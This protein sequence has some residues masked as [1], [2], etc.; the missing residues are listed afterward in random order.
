MTASEYAALVLN[1]RDALVAAIRA[2][3]PAVC[4][5][6]ARFI[7]TGTQ[8][9]EKWTGSL[10]DKETGKTRLLVILMSQLK[11]SDLQATAGA[12]NFKPQI[13]LNFELFH[14]FKLGTD[15]ENSEQV[16]L[17]DALCLQFA[18]ESNRNLP[19]QG[20]IDDYSINLGLRPSS[21]NAMHYGRGT[22]TINFREIR[23]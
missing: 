21:V 6:K 14:D 20:K 15:E 3:L 5:V 8:E 2:A 7:K 10:A 18:I 19:P 9:D 4:K 1:T 11:S 17:A 12:K 16:F 13:R 22:I 23:Y